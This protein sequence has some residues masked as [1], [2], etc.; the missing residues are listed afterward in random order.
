ME[1]KKIKFKNHFNNPSELK[2]KQDP[3]DKIERDGFQ[4]EL[5]KEYKEKN[6][7]WRYVR[8]KKEICKKK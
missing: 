8:W 4:K 3:E 2:Q 6:G 1:H 7:Y 5:K